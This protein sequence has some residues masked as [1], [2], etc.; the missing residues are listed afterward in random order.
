MVS[1]ISMAFAKSDASPYNA[2]DGLW[3]IRYAFDGMQHVSAAKKICVATEQ[4]QPSTTAVVGPLWRAT[5]LAMAM[6]AATE[7]PS[8]LM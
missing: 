1:S 7:P 5:M 4:A 8:E 3:I 2:Q 6:P